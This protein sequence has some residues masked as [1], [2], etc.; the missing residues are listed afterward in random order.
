MFRK[1]VSN[2]TF[3][4][5]LVGQLGFYARRLKK[6]EATRKAGVIFTVLAL[7]LQ[8]FAVFSPPESANAA[9]SNDLIYGGISSKSDLLNNYDSNEKFRKVLTYAGITRDDLVATVTKEINNLSNGKGSKAWKS[10]GYNSFFSASQGEIKYNTGTGATF[11]SR[12][13]YLFNTTAYEKENGAMVK[14]LYGKSKR[15]GEF[16]I[17]Y[18]CGNVFTPNAPTPPPPPPPPSPSPP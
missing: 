9:S 2:V 13:N 3:S 12:P 5:A 17:M 6:E 1:L 16:G 11:Y 7:V 8:S 15:L 14:V 10:W 4:P 18:H